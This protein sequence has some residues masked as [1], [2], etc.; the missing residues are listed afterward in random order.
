MDRGRTFVSKY[1]SMKVIVVDAGLPD[2]IICKKRF[3]YVRIG[4]YAQ[5]VLK[6]DLSFFSGDT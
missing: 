6:I 2:L 3:K 1:R 4:G 5:S